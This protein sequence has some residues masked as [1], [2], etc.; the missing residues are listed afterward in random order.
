MNLNGFRVLKIFYYKTLGNS[1]SRR[2]FRNQFL[3]PIQF[4]DPIPPSGLRSI[5]LPGA[6]PGTYEVAGNAFSAPR[7]VQL[8]AQPL[9]SPCPLPVHSLSTPCPPL[10]TRPKKTDPRAKRAGKSQ[11]LPSSAASGAFAL[12]FQQSSVQDSQVR[13]VR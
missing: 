11:N 10:S 7:P 2:A 9:S 13:T 4:F 5:T 6:L 8:P 3:T 12:T 1:F